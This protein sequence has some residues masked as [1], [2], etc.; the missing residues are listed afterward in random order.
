MA[1]EKWENISDIAGSEDAAALE[2]M[3]LVKTPKMKASTERKLEKQ[4]KLE[5]AYLAGLQRKA[6]GG[7]GLL[8]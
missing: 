5:N 1:E 7:S 6:N 3:H 2:S 8:A 4:P